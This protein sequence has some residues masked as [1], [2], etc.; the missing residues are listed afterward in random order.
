M[1]QTVF[2]RYEKKYLLNEKQYFSVLEVLK[3]CALPDKYGKSTVCS[4][5]YDTPDKRLIRASIERPVYKEKLRLRSYGVPNDSTDCFLE[6]K[7][8]YKG[9]VYKRQMVT[10][11]SNGSIS[12]SGG[13]LLVS[14]PTNSGNGAF[15]YDSS[16]V[17]TGGTAILCGSSGMAQGFSQNSSQA[18][19][20]YTLNSTANAGDSIAVTDSSGKVIASFM[21]SKQ[22]GSIVV[23]SH[24]F[25]V[26]SSYTVTI[27]GTVTDCD[28]NG[29]TASGKVTGGDSS[30]AVEI[31]SVSTSYGSTGGM[32]GMG[33]MGGKPD[34]G[35]GGK[36]PF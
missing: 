17:I 26:G 14:G 8:K 3:D 18:S 2:K 11:Y 12:M 23:S 22:Y 36:M 27:G 21:P 32:G 16:A 33:G 19:F 4:I 5:Y 34:R 29:Y 28:Q 35:N 10:L 25:S 9:V 13:V 7:K 15:D 30:F 24:E 1:F 31:S 20:I 6:L